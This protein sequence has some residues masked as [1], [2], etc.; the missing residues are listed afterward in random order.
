MDI[1]KNRPEGFLVISG[2]DAIT[3]PLMTCGMEGVISVIGN[4][5][6]TYFSKMVHA[7]LEENWKEAGTKH[8]QLLDMMNTIFED[9]SPGGIKVLMSEIGLCTP[10]VRLPL[11]QPSEAVKQKLLTQ[12][13]LFNRAIGHS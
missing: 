2:D 10:E 3:L 9:G 7:I 1:L 8:S 13:G 12:F 6:P 5:F 11:A 4:A